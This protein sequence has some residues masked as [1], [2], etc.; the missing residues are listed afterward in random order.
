MQQMHLEVYDRRK[1]STARWKVGVKYFHLG[2]ERQMSQK[3]LLRNEALIKAIFFPWIHFELPAVSFQG[4]QT[5]S[6]GAH[7]GNHK[8]SRREDSSDV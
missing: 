7:Q 2:D 4:W 8:G 5:E 3:F 6:S 1:Q